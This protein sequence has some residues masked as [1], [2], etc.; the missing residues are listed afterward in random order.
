MAYSSS[1]GPARGAGPSRGSSRGGGGGG[2]ANN[3]TIVNKQQKQ[4]NNQFLGT[5]VPFMNPGDEVAM[6]NGHAWDIKNTRLFRGRFEKYLA[7]PEDNGPDD[8]ADRK[9]MFEIIQALTPKQGQ[10]PSL[11][12]A[13]KCGLGDQLFTDWVLPTQPRQEKVESRCRP[14][15]GNED[16]KTSNDIA[17]THRCLLWGR[18]SRN[19]NY[20]LRVA[21]DVAL[22]R[23]S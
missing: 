10:Q 2:G 1:R 15:N 9:V 6:W 11:H 12:R 8:Q 3:T 23:N 22:T 4:G 5:D 17:Y 16:Q 14:N 13:A 20:E 7:A 18:G 21:W 19:T